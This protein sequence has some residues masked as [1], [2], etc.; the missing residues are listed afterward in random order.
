MALE[1]SIAAEAL[2]SVQSFLKSKGSSLDGPGLKA[3]TA[4]LETLEAGLNGDLDPV[5]FLSSIDPGMGKTLS[6]SMFLKA[7]KE[8]GNQPASS[9]LIGVSRLSEIKSYIEPSGLADTDFGVLTSDKE[10]NALGV[11]KDRH[12][13]APIM[14]T[15]QQMIEK[16]TRNLSFSA[17]SEFHYKDEPRALRI[18]D[19]SIMP[20]MPLS[21]RID[22]LGKLAS[23]LRYRHPR[24]IEAVEGLEETVRHLKAGDVVRVPESVDTLAPHGLTGEVGK[25]VETLG[26]MA[27]RGLLLVNGG[28]GNL[29]LVGSVPSLPDDF[30]PTIIL[31][32][33]GRVRSTYR[34]WEQH[35]GTLRRLPAA[36]HNYSNLTVRLWQRGSG[37]ATLEKPASLSRIVEGVAKVINEEGQQ[38]WLIV[39]YKGNAAIFEEISALVVNEPATRLHP[40]TWGRHHGTNDYR[41]ISNVVIIGQL[42]YGDIS[43]HAHGAAAS[44]LSGGQLSEFDSRD[45]EGGEFQHNLLQA[46]CRSSVRQSRHGK[47][48][49]CRAYVITSAKPDP[50][51]R[52]RATFP[53]CHIR[54]WCPVVAPLTGRNGEAADYLRDAFKDL[55]VDRVRKADVYTKMGIHRS[56]FSAIIGHPDFAEFMGRERIFSE[57]QSFV[58]V[59]VSFEP[60]PGGGWTVDDD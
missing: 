54:D 38:D 43:F 17:A 19:E 49:R 16:R 57:G 37:Q 53:G 12:S 24:F 20:A 32:A 47:A 26:L 13:T 48:G 39:Y 1:G 60:Y 52:V 3:I 18:W 15:T 9:V 7:W 41:H 21:L 8:R 42:N 30:A 4:L 14:F 45:V 58:K 10:A 34:L 59:H 25:V 50:V 11:P 28:N 29:A 5:Y 51:E 56:N 2:Q 23:P 33:S 35:R 46:V 40:L 22:D 36:E 55:K 6:V 44:G 27:G 31:D